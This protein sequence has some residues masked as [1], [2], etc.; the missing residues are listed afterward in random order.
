MANK[1]LEAVSCDEYKVLLKEIYFMILNEDTENFPYRDLSEIQDD[2]TD[3]F[4]KNAP[5]EII[6]ADFNTYYMFVSGLAFGGIEHRLND[7]LERYNTKLWLS[8]SFF[9]W[10]PKYR[11]L[12]RYTFDLYKQFNSNLLLADKLRRKLIELID[13]VENKLRE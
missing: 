11:F 3:E 6:E 13:F 10:F 7:A 2:F 8:K 9:D 1:F 12:E 4:I 5:Q